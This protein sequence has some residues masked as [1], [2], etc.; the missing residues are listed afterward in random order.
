MNSTDKLTQDVIAGN[1]SEALASMLDTA[2][3]N[4]IEAQSHYRQ[5]F[6]DCV[7]LIAQQ[8]IEI[9]QLRGFIYRIYEDWPYIN[10]EFGG[11]DLQ[12]LGEKFG[13]LI[14][15]ARTSFCDDDGPDTLCNCREYF[16][17]DEAASGFDCYRVSPHIA[18]AA[19]DE[20]GE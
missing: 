19:L 13:I 15:E 16:T 1:E 4:V 12:E 14:K 8:E 17:E 2:L 9:K 6:Q 5:L 18:N 3:F 11:A 20:Q 10:N 7:K